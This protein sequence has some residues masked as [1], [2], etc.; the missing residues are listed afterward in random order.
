MRIP[1]ACCLLLCCV[2]DV[3]VADVDLSLIVFFSS[4]PFSISIWP[5]FVFILF[6]LVG[7][8]LSP[9]FRFLLRLV[10]HMIYI[11]IRT[12]ADLTSFTFV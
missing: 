9:R 1:L 2:A 8:M 12:Y 6:F 3:G 10:E 5:S 4:F 11:L 7:T